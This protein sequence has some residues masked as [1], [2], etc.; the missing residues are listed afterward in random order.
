MSIDY[1]ANDTPLATTDPFAIF[2]SWMEAATESEVNDAN[3]M[4]LATVAP[5]GWPSVRT[6]LLKGVD[7]ADSEPRG[8]IFYTNLESRKARELQATHHA[9]MLFHW[10]SVRRQIRIEGSVALVSDAEADAYFATRPRGSQI[11]AWA[12]QQSRPLRNGRS[13]LEQRVTQTEARF[14]GSDVPRPEF[15]SGFRLTPKRI[16]FWQDRQYRLHDRAVFEAGPGG[17]TVERLYP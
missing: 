5:D 16:E 13:E 9:A 6:V 8:F 12:S 10:K 1:L 11:G 17:W 2:D 7:S 4:A 3:A 14:E 15:W